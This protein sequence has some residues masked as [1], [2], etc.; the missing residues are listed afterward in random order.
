MSSR[1]FKW[2][3]VWV[4]RVHLSV[5]YAYPDISGIRT[6][7]RTLVHF[8]HDTF[9][10]G[11]HKTVIDYSTN[12]TVVEYQL[13]APWKSDFIFVSYVHS[14]FLTVYPVGWG[15]RHTFFVR[16]YDKMH[17]TELTGT[18]WLLFVTVVRL[19]SFGDGLPVRNFR[20]KEFYLKLVVMLYS[21]FHGVDVEFTLSADYHLFQFFWVLNGD[22][23]ILFVDTVKDF[24]KF[25]FVWL[26]GSLYCCTV[27]CVGVCDSVEFIVTV[28]FT[29]CIVVLCIFK[30]YGSAYVACPEFSDLDPVFTGNGI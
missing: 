12:Y 30:L 9:K 2:Y 11:R 14:V 6:C 21:P 27:F 7:K 13:T 25:F 1:Q 19:C 17:F 22:R 26:V 23:G 20:C 18:T 15:F 28:F 29:K 5:V 10:Y 4:N 8:F 24:C 3:F 16:F